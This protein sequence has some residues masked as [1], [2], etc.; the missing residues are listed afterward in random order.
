MKK[1][2]NRKMKLA[3][4]GLGAFAIAGISCVGLATLENTQPIESCAIDVPTVDN[5]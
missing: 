5:P 2:L 1:K 3:L 4:A